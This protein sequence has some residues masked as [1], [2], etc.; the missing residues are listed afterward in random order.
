MKAGRNRT[1]VSRP[2]TGRNPTIRRTPIHRCWVNTWVPGGIE[3]SLS[4]PQPDVL[5]LNYRHHKKGPAAHAAR[6]GRKTRHRLKVTSYVC[7][8]DEES[9]PFVHCVCLILMYS[10]SREN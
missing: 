5:P 7:R 9:S 3:P 4:G 2:F 6:P 10:I 8:A 1:C